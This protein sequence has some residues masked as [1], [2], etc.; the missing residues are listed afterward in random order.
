MLPDPCRIGLTGY[1][2]SGKDAV[3]DILVARYGFVKVN[4]SDALDKYLRILNPIITHE[5]RF[6]EDQCFGGDTI[7][8]VRY[9]EICERIPDY[10][11]R[12]RIPEVRELLQRLGADVGRAIDPEMWVKELKKESDKH[13][14]VVTTGIRFPEEAEDLDYLINVTRPGYGPVNGHVSDQAIG[15]IACRADAVI[16]NNGTLQQL[17]NVVVAILDDLM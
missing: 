17:E 10:A 13:R 12:K 16:A 7:V 15:L 1:A 6:I 11:A 4:M 3:A 8:E 2:G 14:R 9:A 5:T